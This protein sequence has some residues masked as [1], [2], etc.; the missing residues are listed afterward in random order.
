MSLLSFSLFLSFYLPSLFLSLFVTGHGGVLSWAAAKSA[1]RLRLGRAASS[2]R[3]PTHPP[4]PSPP[5][6]LLL[7]FLLLF[8]VLLLLL[9][10]S[11]IYFSLCPFSHSTS[12][13]TLG[14]SAGQAVAGDLATPAP[15]G[16]LGQMPPPSPAPSLSFSLILSSLSNWIQLKNLINPIIQTR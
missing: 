5:L 2:R 10:L 4:P 15:T 9:L 13:S 3:G 16:R 11:I 12:F 8:H 6:P 14:A 1:G 7:L